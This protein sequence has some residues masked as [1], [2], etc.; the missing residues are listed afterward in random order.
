MR[1]PRKKL[2]TSQIVALTFCWVI[3]VLMVL[4][5]AQLNFFTIFSIIVSGILVFVP[6]YKQRRKP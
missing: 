3:L 6:I 2:S 5:Y 4:F 1:S